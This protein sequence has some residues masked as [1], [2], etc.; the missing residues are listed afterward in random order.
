MAIIF[1]VTYPEHGS[2]TGE[3]VSASHRGYGELCGQYPFTVVYLNN[4]SVDGSID[5]WDNRFQFGNQFTEVDNCIIGQTYKFNYHKESRS[6]DSDASVTI[7]Y[8]VLDSIE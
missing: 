5:D 1:I 4:Y 3:F 7:E 8:Y 2:I 6:A